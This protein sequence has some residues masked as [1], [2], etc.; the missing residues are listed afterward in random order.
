MAKIIH[1]S[2]LG[3]SYNHLPTNNEDIFATLCGISWDYIGRY[4][5]LKKG[6]I[7]CPDC[8]KIARVVFESCSQDEL[9]GEWDSELDRIYCDKCNS[10]KV[11]HEGAC[12]NFKCENY[13]RENQK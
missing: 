6:K 1:G 7:T 3:I 2:G 11:G 13:K 10:Q 12:I 5:K 8:I 9:G 4:K